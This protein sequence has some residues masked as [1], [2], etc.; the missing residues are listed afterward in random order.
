[1]KEWRF[2][3]HA[4]DM[5]TRRF[6]ANDSHRPAYHF[7]SPSGWM[8]DPNGT[9][10]WNGK[11]HMF[12][13][14][15]PDI[16]ESGVALAHWGHAVSDDLVHWH[17]LPI[18]LAPEPGTYDE[19]GCWS[20]TSIVDGDRVIANYHAHLGGNC[21]AFSN[22]EMLL[23]WEKSPHNPIVPFDPEKTYDP[24]IWKNNGM[25][26]SISG[27][28]TNAKY[29]DGRDQEFGG[30]DIAY[31]YKS[32]DL[33]K[34]DY[35]GIF[36]E[37]GVFTE[38]GEDCACPDFFDIGN[39]HM[40]L[41][42]SHNRGAQYYLGRYENE[43]FF[44]ETHGRMNFTNPS[45]PKLGM[46]GDL[47]AP[48]AWVGPGDR[49]VMIAWITEG[50]PGE[51]L[52]K[53]GWGGI[54]SLPRD[55]SLD[56]EGNLLISPVPELESLRENHQSFDNVVLPANK[57]IVLE[58]IEGNTKELRLEI[59]NR[60]FSEI[61]I[62]VCVSKH[63]IEK[64]SIVY[65]KKDN[66]ISLDPSLSSI[67]DN[68]TG[69]E[70]QIAPLILGDEEPL[71]LSI[72]IDRSVVEVFANGKQCVTKRIYPQLADSIGY[73]VGAMDGT[74]TITRLDAWDMKSIW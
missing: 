15:A 12:Y 54:M 43:R 60:K 4:G 2:S 59:S 49:R 24:C 36:Y 57:N 41:F 48:I 51:S 45:L 26:Y 32:N 28:I 58:N 73:R 37:G 47:A 71:A 67:A 50:R 68:L 30:K 33:A 11:W 34:W 61:R 22:D 8:N 18:A 14:Y 62:E 31:L 20:G 21:I 69:K 7:S 46:S 56:S 70:P 23:D 38:P 25:Y 66:T 27:R 40:L 1:M 42:L 35:S 55:L 9:V 6:Y 19:N 13:Q 52:A 53:I 44:P 63:G 29:G 39:R 16:W 74:A 3:M 5:V 64:T 10:F 72:F 65:S 17:D